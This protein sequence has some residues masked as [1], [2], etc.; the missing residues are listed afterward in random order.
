MK[1]KQTFC[2]KR[3]LKQNMRTIINV[4]EYFE[5]HPSKKLGLIFLDAT[6]AYDNINWNFMLELFRQMQ[7]QENFR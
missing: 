1:T 4:L 5:V 7:F 2:Q 3:H 6:K